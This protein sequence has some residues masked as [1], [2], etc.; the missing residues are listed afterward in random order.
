MRPVHLAF[1]R[2]SALLL[3]LLFSSTVFAGSPKVEV[4]HVPPG[5]PDNFHTI[6]I[7]E[8]ALGKHLGHGDLAGPCNAICSQLCDDG[9][10][11]TVDDLGDCETNGCPVVSLP[12]DCSDGSLCTDDLCD[13][14]AGCSNPVSVTCEPTNLCVTSACDPIFGVCEETAKTCDDG[15]SCNPENGMCEDNEPDPGTPNSC[16][17]F[18]GATATLE[19]KIDTLALNGA[20]AECGEF[21]GFPG[22]EGIIFVNTSLACS[23]PMCADLDP[24]PSCSGPS[25]GSVSGLTAEEN[26]ACQLVMTETCAGASSA[27]QSSSSATTTNLQVP[28]ISN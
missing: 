8:K 25:L 18:G 11:C 10:A 23:G 28:F 6:K 12:V 7:S 3:V 22:L 27:A 16:P 15:E 9:N 2:F 14:S 4:C 21:P 1:A 13:P 5:N 19:D 24:V 26:T 20:I 17:C